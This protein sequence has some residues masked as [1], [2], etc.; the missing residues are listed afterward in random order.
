MKINHDL[1]RALYDLRQALLDLGVE[2]LPEMR[3]NTHDD[4]EKFWT[5]LQ[6]AGFMIYSSP[7]EYQ[8]EWLMQACG[9]R[10]EVKP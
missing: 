3:F 10:I 5:G 4:R 7:N 9:M 2:H 8:R 6:A 1:Y